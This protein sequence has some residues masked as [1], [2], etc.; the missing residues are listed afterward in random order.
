[1]YGGSVAIPFS[2]GLCSFN[3][4]QRIGWQEFWSQSLFHQVCVRS[5]FCPDGPDGPLSQSLFHQV[6]VR[7][8]ASTRT[9]LLLR[10]AIPFSSGLCSFRP[11][12]PAPFSPPCRNPFFIRSVF[13]PQAGSDHYAGLRSQSLFHQVCVRS[14]SVI[15]TS[16][17][18]VG[19]Q[20]LFHQV[21][22]RS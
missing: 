7:S 20:S 22:V 8:S 11:T 16:G 18:S 19:S 12:I 15:G 9:R 4:R 13:V 3:P 17:T 14:G 1:M 2:S 6:C 5:F 21:C 10:V